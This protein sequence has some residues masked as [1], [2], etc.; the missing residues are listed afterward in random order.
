MATTHTN[1]R[2]F[3]AREATDGGNLVAAGTT[4]RKARLRAAGASGLA[5]VAMTLGP[6]AGA[7]ADDG[8]KPPPPGA[9]II[10]Q[11]APGVVNA[12]SSAVRGADKRGDV[13]PG[14]PEGGTEVQLSGGNA[15][16]P[17]KLT[18]FAACPP[19]PTTSKFAC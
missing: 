2:R 5:F 14:A 12:G 7:F 16:P 4:M 19:D 17:D 13:L 3:R 8:N 9:P 6:M 10:R 15:S 11:A 1:S 18:L